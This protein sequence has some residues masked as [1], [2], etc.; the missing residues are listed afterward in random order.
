MFPVTHILVLTNNNRGD[1]VNTFILRFMFLC[2]GISVFCIA[3]GLLL[4]DAIKPLQAKR[5]FITGG[6]VLLVG[7]AAGSFIQEGQRFSSVRPTTEAP[8]TSHEYTTG[9]E[10]ADGLDS[11]LFDINIKQRQT[12]EY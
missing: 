3:H 1:R 8:P 2:I 9:S 11:D 12:N 6:I 7:L 10:E 4:H 5:S